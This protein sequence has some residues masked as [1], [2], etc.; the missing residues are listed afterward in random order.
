MFSRKQKREP[1]SALRAL[2]NA[3]ARSENILS[4]PDRLAA[5]I[6]AY[7][8]IDVDPQ[9]REDIFNVLQS[10][11]LLAETLVDNSFSSETACEQIADQ[12]EILSR[13]LRYI[14]RRPVNRGFSI[15]LP[16]SRTLVG[17]FSTE[18][19]ANSHIKI[20]QALG[21]AVDAKVVPVTIRCEEAIQPDAYIPEVPHQPVQQIAAQENRTTTRSGV[22]LPSAGDDSPDSEGN[23]SE[24][25]LNPGTP[26]TRAEDTPVPTTDASELD[27]LEAELAKVNN[28]PQPEAKA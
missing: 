6:Q 21:A 10:S 25:P 23:Y 24:I 28:P 19:E 8:Q 2:L 27:R 9:Y 3:T 17:Q 13:A 11:I 12:I 5:V 7:D 20:L 1:T 16:R 26:A 15:L 14:Q 22:P 18:A 4:I